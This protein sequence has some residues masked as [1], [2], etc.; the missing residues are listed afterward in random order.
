MSQNYERSL[1]HRH[2]GCNTPHSILKRLPT[3]ISVDPWPPKRRP[4]AKIIR[5]ILSSMNVTSPKYESAESS[6]LEPWLG[7]WMFQQG[8]SK[9]CCW[10]NRFEEYRVGGEDIDMSHRESGMLL[11]G[12]WH[13][14]EVGTVGLKKK[15]NRGAYCQLAQFPRLGKSDSSPT[16]I[17]AQ[18][19][20]YIWLYVSSLCPS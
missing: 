17:V 15:K 16:S 6:V 2:K 19:A 1:I 10:Q 4:M 12:Y 14:G 9:H 13:H 5:S 8:N 3:R 11:T 18:S 20:S 7:L